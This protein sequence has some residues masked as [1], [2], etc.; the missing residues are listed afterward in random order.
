[1]DIQLDL[2]THCIETEL[3]RQYNRYISEYFKSGPEE[4]DLIEPKIDT[5]RMALEILNFARLRARYRP[6]CGGEACH[7]IIL[8]RYEK[9]L[10]ITID[11]Q[12]HYLL[13]RHDR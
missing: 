12:R 5:L 4:K 7:R 8:S 11:G 9:N 2:S 6:L 10:F 1:M 3:K 13:D